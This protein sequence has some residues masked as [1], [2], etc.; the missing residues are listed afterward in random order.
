VSERDALLAAI[1]ANPED[2]TPRLVFADWLD[3]HEPDA[4]PSK[5]KGAGSSPSP[6]AAL[7]RAECEFARLQED[8]AAAA[9]VYNFFDEIDEGDGQTFKGVRWERALP[10]MARRIELAAT[11][12]R[13]RSK[14]RAA[15]AGLLPRNAGV[16][17]LF[18]TLRGFPNTLYITRQNKVDV[19]R[20]DR[21][22]PFRIR[23]GDEGSDLLMQLVADGLLRNVRA[24]TLPG[25]RGDLM[26]VLS[27][28]A[29]TAGIREFALL[30][31][32]T[33]VDPVVRRLATIANWFGL[34]TLRLEQSFPD[35]ED[36]GNLFGAGHLHKLTRLHVHG[37]G[38]W[39][40]HTIRGLSAF[41]ELRDLRLI[42]C[43][44]DDA[45]AEQLADM[46]GLANLRTLELARN[47][48]TGAGASA[49]LASPHLKNLAALDFEDNPVRG[50]DRTVLANAP[51]G[52]LRALAVQGCRLT[53]QD[54]TAL[55][56][57]PR[58]SELVCFAACQSL[59]ERAIARLVRGFG[60]RAPAVLYLRENGI[61]TAGA[62]A[63][64]DWPAAAQVD[65]LHL[66][67]N[68]LSTTGAKALAC[69]PH[70]KGSPTSAR[71]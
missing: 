49:L 52:G 69:C 62:G 35:Q 11:A 54:V 66:Q 33:T 67:G 45:A 2:D 32:A 42:G 28:S 59:T 68:R 56:T 15:L 21:L 10:E 50:L 13:A 48:I 30:P 55:T 31:G 26:R 64:A 20:L 4:K 25:H 24:L 23:F 63:L 5:R 37:A 14:A 57:S 29:D 44:L 65:M 7:I 41:T 51:A 40:R 61:S 60:T 19:T 9:A 39:T 12:K 36:W 71:T 22:P 70:L 34:R 18:D 8:G 6:W 46:P 1:R 53:A 47:R 58:V 27:A 17:A 43:G 3:E 16:W 38:D